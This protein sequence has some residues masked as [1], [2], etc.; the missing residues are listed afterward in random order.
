MPTAS[1]REYTRWSQR[2]R[3]FSVSLTEPPKKNDAST[4]MSVMAKASAPP[5]ANITVRAIG[6]NIFPS[7]PVSERIGRYTMVIMSTPKNTGDP[8]SRAAIS[9]VRWRSSTVSTRPN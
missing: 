9:T 8:T 5:R 4:G 1:T 2:M 6:R 3:A 7:T